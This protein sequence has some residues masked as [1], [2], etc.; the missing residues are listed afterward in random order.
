MTN[1]QDVLR[2]AKAKIEDPDHWCTGEFALNAYGLPIAPGS[3]QAARWCS[4]GAIEAIL[5]I[6]GTDTLRARLKL[7][8]AA[9]DNFGHGVTIVNDHLGHEAV[10]RMYDEAIKLA[11]D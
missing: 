10:M 6:P 8:R 3:N 4:I 5:E 9:F 11:D 2:Q 1:I 7:N